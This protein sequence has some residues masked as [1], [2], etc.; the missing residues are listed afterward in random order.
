MGF[1]SEHVLVDLMS[2]THDHFFFSCSLQL[3]ENKLIKLTFFQL[4]SDTFPHTIPINPI[5][6]CK[7]EILTN[8]SFR[9][10]GWKHDPFLKVPWNPHGIHGLKCEFGKHPK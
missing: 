6:F 4:L 7:G 3:P 8:H 5:T 1:D 10:Y 9:P 2:L